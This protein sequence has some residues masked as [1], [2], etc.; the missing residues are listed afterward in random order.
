MLMDQKLDNEYLPL[1]CLSKGDA[2]KALA[3]SGGIY[4]ETFQTRLLETFGDSSNSFSCESFSYFLSFHNFD[5]LIILLSPISSFL[6]TVA[7]LVPPKR[8]AIYSG[9]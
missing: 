3:L 6:T 2:N 1:V 7:G 9:Y 4:L 8:L 5:T